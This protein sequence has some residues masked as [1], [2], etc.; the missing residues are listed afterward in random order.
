MAQGKS[1][2]QHKSEGKTKRPVKAKSKQAAVA[3]KSVVDSPVDDPKKPEAVGTATSAQSGQ[4]LIEKMTP[5]GFGAFVDILKQT[6]LEGGPTVLL[7]QGLDA[8]LQR[9]LGLLLEK[10]S[11]VQITEA[12]HTLQREVVTVEKDLKR[13]TAETM[14]LNNE[15]VNILRALQIPLVILDKDLFVR[16]CS[17]AADELFGNSLFKVGQKV[18]ANISALIPGIEE[19]VSRV[20]SGE[21]LNEMDILDG[22]DQKLLLRFHPFVAA[23][24]RTEGVILTFANIDVERRSEDLLRAHQT[25]EQHV[26][27]VVHSVLMV[28]DTFQNVRMISRSGCSLL[29]FDETEII[30]KNWVDEFIP[31]SHRIVGA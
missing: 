30:G 26:L 25:R 20:V 27:D 31:R 6:K 22:D 24:G 17:P 1:L 23:H 16:R 29:G 28:L 11:H 2:S 4:L 9:K 15:V 19:I 14:W 8:D 12:M 5:E 10:D 13:V 3:A 18:G 21:T 7:A